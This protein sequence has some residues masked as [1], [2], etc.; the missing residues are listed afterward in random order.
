LKC[1]LTDITPSGG[2][3]E[4]VL[5]A[6]EDASW[7]YYVAGGPDLYVAHDSGGVWTTKLVAALSQADRNAWRGEGEGQ[8]TARVSPNGEWLAFMSQRSLTGYDNRDALSG[9]PDQEVYLYH[10]PQDLAS[11]PGALACASCDPTGARP[12]GVR[13][14]R[15]N[16]ETV[17]DLPLVGGD[18][19]YEGSTWLAANVPTWVPYRL[20]AVLY[21]PRYL[22]SSGRLFFD[23]SDALVPQDVNGT[24]DV[25][26]YE[27]EGVPAGEH[28]CSSASASGSEVFKPGGVVEVE[29]RQVREG[30][31]CVALISSGE[32]P[33]ESAFLD[34]SENGSDVFFL[35][36]AQLAPQDTDNALDVYD[37]QECTVAAPCQAS[38]ERSPACTTEAS[39][40]PAS[41]PQ[42]SIFGLSGSATFSGAGNLAPPGG[43]AS[44]PPKKVTKK[45]VKCK[46]PKKLSHGKCVKSRKKTKARKSAHTNR[47]VK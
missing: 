40:R 36:T 39:C 22:S 9:Q 45:T 14:Y 43:G 29:A 12:H 18:R 28:A 6:S 3:Q 37:A 44:N 24:E 15:E 33:Q 20:D 10:A 16:E 47:R 42:P 7:V 13:Y 31:G 17:A 23:S 34:A 21:Q 32:S 1:A 2:V 46:R 38:A 25:Y 11:E 4:L 35:T 26:E 41:P 5:G 27:P 8:A 30:A 19:V